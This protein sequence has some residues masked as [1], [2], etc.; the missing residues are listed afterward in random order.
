MERR[1]PE[2]LALH[3]DLVEDL[4]RK[5]LSD[6]AIARVNPHGLAFRAIRH[7]SSRREPSANSSHATIKHRLRGS[8]K[9]GEGKPDLFAVH[10]RSD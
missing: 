3:L 4:I 10:R 5:E 6:P 8:L 1:W 9:R 7:L 2:L